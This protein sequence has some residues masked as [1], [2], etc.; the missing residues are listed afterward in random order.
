MSLHT[1]ESSY[2]KSEQMQFATL[3]SMKL[4]PYTCSH[5]NM[6]MRTAGRMCIGACNTLTPL[7]QSA[8]LHR[9]T[10]KH[11]PQL[12]QKCT[13]W[14]MTVN[15]D[16]APTTVALHSTLHSTLLAHSILAACCACTCTRETVWQSILITSMTIQ[17]SWS[18]S[19]H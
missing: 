16:C 2:C 19:L 1:G 9:I 18:A 17:R 10:C 13:A 7:L 3:H 5:C 4:T 11:M 12:M 8:C 15:T 14:L 6:S